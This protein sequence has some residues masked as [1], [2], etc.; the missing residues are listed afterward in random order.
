VYLKFSIGNYSVAGKRGHWT[1]SEDISLRY[2]TLLNMTALLI[3]AR[4]M[5]VTINDDNHDD[6]DD[7]SK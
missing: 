4:T 6:V 7:V 2:L 3:L 1:A 5:R